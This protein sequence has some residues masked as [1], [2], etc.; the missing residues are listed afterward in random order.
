M[1]L[2]VMALMISLWLGEAARANKLSLV[3]GGKAKVSKV[4]G[5]RTPIVTINKLLLQ[6][7]LASMMAAGDGSSK[8]VGIDLGTTNSVIAYINDKGEPEVLSNLEGDKTTP[9]VVLFGGEGTVVGHEAA[10]SISYEPDSTFSSF[11]RWIG[12]DFAELEEEGILDTV[13]YEIKKGE[14]GVPVVVVDGTEYNA[15]QLSALVLRKLKEDAE[16]VLGEEITRAVISVPAYF[17]G[18]QR[19]ATLEAG[20][21]AGLTVERLIAE[22][23]AAAIKFG[24]QVGEDKKVAVYDLGGGTFD[25]SILE[26]SEAEGVE[27]NEVKA[28]EGDSLLGGDDFDQAIIDYLVAEIKTSKGVDV[29]GDQEAMA[30]LKEYAVE[31]KEALTSKDLTTIGIKKLGDESVTMR[32]DLTYAR[33]KELTKD[34]VTRTIEKTEE[35]LEKAGLTADDIDHFLMAGGSIRM[36][37]IKEAVEE[38]FGADKVSYEEN[39]DEVVALGAALQ[40]G[41]FSGDVEGLIVQEVTAQAFGI[42]TKGN[43]FSKVVDA[44]TTLPVQKTRSD[45]STSYD[46]QPSIRAIVYQGPQDAEYTEYCQELC[47]IVIDGIPAAPRGVPQ[48]EVAF[49]IDANGILKVSVKDIGTGQE[50]NAK[51]ST[52]AISPERIDSMRGAIEEDSEKISARKA[53]DDLISQIEGLIINAKT[54]LKDNGNKISEDDQKAIQRSIETAEQVMKK[55]RA[56]VEL[57]SLQNVHDTFEQQWHKVTA[58]LYGSNEE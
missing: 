54:I 7:Q 23:T 33:F 30:E 48:F 19:Q 5:N 46:N 13:H 28:T 21:L 4:L 6:Q 52:K 9:S 32:V 35:A 58:K 8:V 43:V 16:R 47:E 51:V 26:M 37:V 20:A 25:V 34:L 45:F 40:A 42:G 29:T 1:K 24:V 27:F 3:R 15:Q 14:G 10:R 31:A 11:K 57:K 38:F 55:D 49:E 56:E 36:R 50:K 39:P 53:K 22:P 41:V 17:N 44:N 12:R 2:L 18:N